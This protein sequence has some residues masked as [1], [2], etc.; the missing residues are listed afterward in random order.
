MSSSALWLEILRGIVS[1]RGFGARSAF[2]ENPGVFSFLVNSSQLIASLRYT[3][4]R[5]IL[6][7]SGRRAVRTATGFTTKETVPRPRLCRSRKRF[8]VQPARQISGHRA[9]DRAGVRAAGTKSRA[10]HSGDPNSSA[11][12]SSSPV[13]P[14]SP[15]LQARNRFLNFNQ[16]SKAGAAS[17]GERSSRHHKAKS[18]GNHSPGAAPR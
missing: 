18:P 17:W 15:A 2:G 11:C 7:L 1:A 4:T 12:V 14:C 6:N 16:T 10:E 9:R 3:T 8:F 5:V 13:L